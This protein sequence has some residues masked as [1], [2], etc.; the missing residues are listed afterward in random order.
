[1]KADVIN[2]GSRRIS[3]DETWEKYYVWAEEWANWRRGS[4]T[5][6]FKT[7]SFAKKAI[8]E[9]N[10]AAEKSLRTNGAQAILEIDGA[11]IAK[12]KGE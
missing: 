1:M 2:Y 8:D 5:R 7:L 11:A 12:A 4:G 10:A 3:Y 9:L 6:E